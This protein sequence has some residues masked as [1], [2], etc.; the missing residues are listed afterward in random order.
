MLN[1]ISPT[2]SHISHS[3]YN[4]VTHGISSYFKLC[5]KIYSFFKSKVY[6][7]TSPS[8]LLSEK[9]ISDTLTTK[10]QAAIKIQRWYRNRLVKA[11][12]KIM[13]ETEKTKNA[14][15]L[16]ITNHFGQDT[17]A[18]ARW[19]KIKEFTKH[20]EKDY[21]VFV[22]SSSFKHAILADM[23][24]YLDSPTLF[25]THY[26]RWNTHKKFRKN[27]GP[28]QFKNVSDY[29]KSQLCKD[30]NEGRTT[31]D[32]NRHLILSCDAYLDNKGPTESAYYFFKENK[33]WFS[34]NPMFVNS[35]FKEHIT[36]SDICKFAASHDFE[37]TTLFPKTTFGQGRVYVIAIPKKT[38]QNKD[39]CYAW[40]AHP[41]GKVCTHPA[42]FTQSSHQ[43]F[44]NVLEKHTKG[45]PVKTCIGV[46]GE[47]QYR[48]LPHNLDKDPTK[49][50][51]AF[52]SLNDVQKDKYNAA[53]QKLASLLKQCKRLE[54]ISDN[55][56]K[57]DLVSI[58]LRTRFHLTKAP[59]NVSSPKKSYFQ[60]FKDFLTSIKESIK[61]FLMSTF[62]FLFPTSYNKLSES[63]KEQLYIKG[64][65]AILNSKK[66]ILLKHRVYLKE[67]L[68]QSVLEQLKN[69][70][71]SLT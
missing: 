29:F 25:P 58:L 36:N 54:S 11:P 70:G 55:T 53:F 62:S 45:E 31:D 67:N 10:T 38:L 21:Y 7:P 56:L 46:A 5:E 16:D 57:E 27:S 9:I 23:R 35:F 61:E 65:T 2:F 17:T 15:K 12:P 66:A 24:T 1:K 13:E 60:R 71:I 32:N 68:P 40:R 43:D 41:F 42:N 19:K 20:L 48:L 50:V 37:G 63:E 52:D 8:T 6:K 33:S 51:F 64:I 34:T 59:S 4:L 28:P 14:M 69:I 39:T 3:A 30:I 18:E 49:L 47:A 22:H 44:I 26:S